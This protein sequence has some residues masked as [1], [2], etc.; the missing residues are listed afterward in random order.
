METLPSSLFDYELPQG[1]IAQTPAERRDQS[2]LL[3]YRRNSGKVSHHRFCELASLL[4]EGMVLF[5]N[6]ARVLRARLRAERPTGGAVEC[7]LLR[8]GTI[9]SQW[10]C[11]LKPGKKLPVGSTFG[12]D[13][14]F[15]AKVLKKQPDGECLVEFN[16]LNGRSV[17]DIAEAYGEIPLPPYISRCSGPSSTVDT[18]RYQTVYADTQKTVAV[19][20]P[21]AGLHFTEELLAL[22]AAQGHPAHDI[23]LHV[24]LGTFR[25]IAT[26]TIQE[27]LMH[28]ELYEISA[29]TRTALAQT[30]VESRLAIGTTTLRAIEDYHRS[31]GVQQD[32]SKP[33]IADARLFLYPPAT[34]SAGALLTNFHLPRST[35][36]CLLS[37]FLA[38]GELAGIA[39]FKELYAEA[40]SNDYRFYSYGDAM[41]VLA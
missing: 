9:P 12:G 38:P 8:P 30:P 20:A 24:G 31:G 39:L 37:A 40:L 4:P 17:T 35:L 27:H 18:E 26:D 22:L 41:L 3:V 2:R 14:Q 19:A 11:L 25:P 36:L 34:F 13:G 5:R 23:T 6:N 15:S 16:T 32:V 28:G 21:T 33:W 10:W 7:L 29:R 1:A